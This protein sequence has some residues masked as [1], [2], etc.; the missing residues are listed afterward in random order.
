MFYSSNHNVGSDFHLDESDLE[1]GDPTVNFKIYNPLES[2]ASDSD[3]DYNLLESENDDSVRCT[4]SNS[5]ED[6]DTTHENIPPYDLPE[7]G[8]VPKWRYTWKY[9]Y[10]C[11]VRPTWDKISSNYG[12]IKSQISVLCFYNEKLLIFFRN[13]DVFDTYEEY[14]TRIH[15][16]V[17]PRCGG[18]DEFRI[19]GRGI[20]Q[21]SL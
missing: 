3:E 17:R 11:T 8:L 21:K 2:E 7:V 18:T 5:D 19:G 4:S 1:D 16:T 12:F 13:I 9:I 14:L 10:H 6:G 15:V 20:P